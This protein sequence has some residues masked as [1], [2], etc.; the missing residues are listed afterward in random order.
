MKASTIFRAYQKAV[1]Y[2]QSCAQMFIFTLGEDEHTEKLLKRSQRQR[3]KFYIR[4]RDLLE[5][6]DNNTPT[7]TD[8]QAD[9]IINTAIEG[10]INYWAM[11][12][13]YQCENPAKA[14]IS[15]FE[16]VK[17]YYI[18]RNT[19]RLGIRRLLEHGNGNYYDMAQR[20]LMDDYDAIDADLCIQM[21]LFNEERYA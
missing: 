19:V 8:E 6:Y 12:E 4:I 15:E 11:P 3:D 5:S 18:N 10:G 14:V 2:H 16:E 13:E 17:L 20:L 21:A 7:I 9:C 1:D